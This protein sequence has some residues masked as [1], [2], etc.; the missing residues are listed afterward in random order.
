MNFSGLRKCITQLCLRMQPTVGS[1]LYGIQDVFQHIRW[2]KNCT[3]YNIFFSF[4]VIIE[5]DTK[6][7]NAAVFTIN[8]EDHTLGNALRT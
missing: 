3:L 7:P 1:T 5:K 6:V 4:R 2:L 8:K